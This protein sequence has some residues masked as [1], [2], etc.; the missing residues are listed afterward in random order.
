MRDSQDV[1]ISASHAPGRIAWKT[2]LEHTGASIVTS[3]DH[4]KVSRLS[5]VT[6]GVQPG[7]GTPFTFHETQ[8]RSFALA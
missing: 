4:I 6:E 3:G 7:Q 8:P 5:L 2:L 1:G